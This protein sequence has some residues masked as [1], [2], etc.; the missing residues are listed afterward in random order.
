MMIFE[1]LH[2]K[3]HVID[4]TPSLSTYRG[5]EILCW[6][7]TYMSKRT[8]NPNWYDRGIVESFIILDDDNDMEMLAPRLCL[9][10]N[11]DGLTK[12]VADQAIKMLHEPVN[13]NLM[14]EIGNA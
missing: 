5:T 12:E 4:V 7:F 9:C 8:K 2:C 1:L 14:L 11:E 13:L 3:A 10:K 6:L